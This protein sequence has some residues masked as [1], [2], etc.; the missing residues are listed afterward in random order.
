MASIDLTGIPVIDNHCHGLYRDQEPFDPVTWRRFFTESHDP[1]MAR[2]H[3]ANTVFYR[4]LLHQLADFLECEPSE[5][6][7]LA[8]RRAWRHG[9]LIR[10][11][12][13][14]ANI[15]MLLID[16]GYPSPARV[17]PGAAGCCR[18]SD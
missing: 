17:L 3:V 1:E 12:L 7:V 9:E 4:R 2:D 13:Q 16:G 5:E 10:A 15:D 14:T 6:A 8:T 11:L 18:S